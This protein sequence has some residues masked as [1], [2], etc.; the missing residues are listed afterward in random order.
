[1]CLDRG[2]AMHM[3]LKDIK[4]MSCHLQR[5]QRHRRR[6]H[7]HLW[8]WRRR[9]HLWWERRRRLMLRHSC[10]WAWHKRCLT[11]IVGAAETMNLPRSDDDA[12]RVCWQI[13]HDHVLMLCACFIIS[14]FLSMVILM[15]MV[16]CGE[17]M[18]Y[19]SD[20]CFLWVW[21]SLYICVSDS[22]GGFLYAPTIFDVW[23]LC[24]FRKFILA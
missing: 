11:I 22:R 4:A 3:D 2:I 5:Q 19:G 16:L 8:W 9:H 7:H 23:F 14:W 10:P 15:Y 12:A 20:A 13:C 1:M 6:H 18:S 17:W 21:C 24:F